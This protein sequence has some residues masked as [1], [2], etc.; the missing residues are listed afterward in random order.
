MTIRNKITLWNLLRNTVLAI[1][2]CIAIIFGSI[3]ISSAQ[4]ENG[5]DCSKPKACV[6]EKPN[7]DKC[8]VGSSW[9]VK[10][11]KIED[12]ICEKK[13]DL[14]NVNRAAAYQA[15]LKTLEIEQLKC[16]NLTL[17]KKLNEGGKNTPPQRNGTECQTHTNCASGYCMPGPDVNVGGSKFNYCTAK[18][19]NCAFPGSDGRMYGHPEIIGS[20]LLTCANPGGGR[21]A[22]YYKLK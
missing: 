10:L 22:Q 21:W 18:S 14:I 20:D 15:C 5:F 9:F 17:Q 2:T 19:K 13:R 7:E 3:S 12:R 6:R 16:T 11:F 4:S 8:L 1:P